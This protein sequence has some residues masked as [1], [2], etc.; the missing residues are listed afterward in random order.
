[1]DAKSLIA[2]ALSFERT[3]QWARAAHAYDLVLEAEPENAEVLVRRTA[4]ACNL[5][6]LESVAAD[7]LRTARRTPDS[8]DIQSLSAQLLISIGR[9]ADAAQVLRTAVARAPVLRL[10]RLLEQAV[11][12]G[13][14]YFQ[15]LTWLHELRAPRAYLEIGIREGQSLR[16]ARPPTRAFG[17]DPAPCLETTEF[18]ADTRIFEVTSDAFFAGRLWCAAGEDIAFDLAFI[19]GLHVFEQV[20]TDFINVERHSVRHGVIAIHDTVPLVPIS[21]DRNPVAA[22][23]CGD[24]WKIVPCLERF[25]PDL[26]VATIPTAPSGLTIVTGLDPAS[27]VL[28]D[29]FE[30]IVREFGELSFA[31]HEAHLPALLAQANERATLARAAER[32][33]A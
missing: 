30:A 7:L 15:H 12:P 19:D 1:L 11:F 27:T 24:V 32:A 3:A 25:R 9:S 26:T 21:A 28:A 8:L 10:F 6:D 2:L 22:F 18:Q 16:L 13:P 33:P 29:R 23:W 5:G 14:T 31:S 20:L 17:V 4:A